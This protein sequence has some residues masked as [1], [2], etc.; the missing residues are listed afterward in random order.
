MAYSTE[1][2]E[3][4]VNKFINKKPSPKEAKTAYTAM[5][6]AYNARKPK[7]EEDDSTFGLQTR[8]DAIQKLMQVKQSKKSDSV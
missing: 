4:I 2:L 7:G 1:I 5:V 6:N 3:E 8:V